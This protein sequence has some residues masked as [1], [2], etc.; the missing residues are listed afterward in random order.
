MVDFI[1]YGLPACGRGAALLFTGSGLVV[2]WAVLGSFG[3]F[4]CTCLVLLW[5]YGSVVTSR[6]CYVLSMPRC[7]AYACASVCLQGLWKGKFR[8]VFTS[9]SAEPRA[10]IDLNVADHVAHV[11]FE[12]GCAVV[13]SVRKGLADR[14]C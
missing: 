14:A 3:C 10:G 11:H 5:H 13:G 6:A 2:R 7:C 12:E 9:S 8:H 4:L 1:A